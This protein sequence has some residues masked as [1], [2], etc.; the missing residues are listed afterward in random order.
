M[1]DQVDLAQ[2]QVDHIVSSY[3]Q[4]IRAQS[5][6]LEA[7]PTGFCLFCEADVAN[8]SRWCDAYCRD[9]WEAE[10]EKDAKLQAQ[11]RV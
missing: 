11:A 5:R 4:N 9:R 7:Q 6:V 2:Q 8:D 10:R 3:I 1:A